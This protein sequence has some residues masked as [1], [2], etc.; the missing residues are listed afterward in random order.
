MDDSNIP[1]LLS[2]D[3]QRNSNLDLEDELSNFR[4]QWQQEIKSRSPRGQPEATDSQND[5]VLEQAKVLFL[6]GSQLEQSGRLYE[7][8][9]FYKRATQ[10]V[11]DIEFQVDFT[12]L[13]GSRE[14]Q[15]S[16]S[17]VG[18]VDNEELEDNL[19][20]HLQSL[21][22][23]ENVN[24]RKSCYPEYEQRATHISVLPVELLNYILR[25]VVSIDLDMKSLEN[26]SE[27]CRGFY[28]A[29]RDEGIWRSA[30]QTVW[31]SSTGKCKKFGGWRNMYIQRSHLLYN[32]CYISKLS[33]VRP[34][35]KSLDG[36]YRPF[37]M[38][39]Y[40]RYVRFF[41]DG[42]VTIMTSP[43]DPP[44]VLPKLK[45]KSTKDT[46][47]LTGVFK[48]IGD[49]V[50]AVLKRVKTKDDTIPYYKKHQR[51]RNNNDMEMTY[52]VELELSN[53]GKKSFAKLQWIDYSVTT[54]YMMTG[55]EN[56]CQLLGNKGYPDLIFSRVRSYTSSSEIP[57][58]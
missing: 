55:Q 37:H 30:C 51:Q 21:Q 58:L 40:Y 6:K 44:S 41:P 22:L 11:P 42:A 31:G 25:W 53:I 57:L 12:S 54:K 18:S 36:Y 1:S 3:V 46:G 32:G 45:H 14:R 28:L 50:T 52:H 20:E 47:M 35:E 26:F 34:G 8:V 29:A 17:S 15:E 9:E 43:D 49:R 56:T 5:Y 23:S 19:V 7:A 13:H 2:S 33:Y 39:E 4:S 16:E 38:V 27:V 10:L 48:Q 24:S